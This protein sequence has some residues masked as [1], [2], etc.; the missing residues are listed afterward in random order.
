[1]CECDKT[2]YINMKLKAAFRNGS[3]VGDILLL[4]GFFLV[5]GVIGVLMSTSLLGADL[6]NMRVV[7]WQ[8]AIQSIAMFTLPPILFAY[9]CTYNVGGFLH[10]EKKPRLSIIVFVVLLLVLA[11][12]AI[13]WLS[14]FNQQMSLPASL[15]GIEKW[16]KSSEQSMAVLTQKLLAVSSLSGLF[17]NV[18]VIAAIP[19]IGEE[20]FFRGAIQGI[21]SSKMNKTA[22]IW[23]TA[24]VF[25]AIHLQFYGFVPRML[26]GALFGFI[27][28]WS[29]TLWLPVVAH[30]TNNVMAVLFY[31]FKCKGYHLPDID[32]LGTGSTWWLGVLSLGATVGGIM[33]LKRILQSSENK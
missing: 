27:L 19:A 31:Y 20:L 23:I 26:M 7:K 8:Q 2:Q 25:S 32:T 14:Y 12:P 22:A 33:M 13:N 10:V 15:S 4:F 17:L 9:L 28:L 30:F 16:M 18:I 11:I 24:V 6:N 1:M 29:D 3:I 21:F 5:F